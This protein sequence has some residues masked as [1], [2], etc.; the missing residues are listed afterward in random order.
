MKRLLTTLLIACPLALG[1]CD[2]SG[3]DSTSAAWI[4]A[5]TD[6]LPADIAELGLYPDLGDVSVVHPRATLYTPRW[7]LWTNGGLKT[8]YV[9][10]PEGMSVNATTESPWDFPVGSMLFKTFAFKRTPDGEPIPVET[11]VMRR[12][13]EGWIY[14]GYQWSEDGATATLRDVRRSALVQV[15]DDAGEPFEHRIPNKLDCESCHVSEPGEVLGFGPRQ[16]AADDLSAL[17]GQG[18]LD[19]SP[20]PYTLPL[21]GLDGE[22][23]AY[24]V[25]NCTFCHN[26]GS[27]ASNAFDMRPEV[28]LENVINTPTEGSGSTVGLRVVPGSPE[29]SVLFQAVS[30]ESDDP[31]LKLMP[32]D[33]LVQLRDV[34]GIEMLRR[35]INSL[36]P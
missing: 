17:A 25:A 7:P 6:E 19:V 26:G 14:D 13:D 2:D 32:P 24:F 8:R 23:A 5:P 1:A 9:V 3:E 10:L 34:E 29:E 18:V 36:E 27:G 4:D 20:E 12:T 28:L 11:R 31:E 33:D 16:L 15:Y 21:E 30:G 35:W 22:I